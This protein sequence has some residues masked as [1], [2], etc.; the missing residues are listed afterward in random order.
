MNQWVQQRGGYPNPINPFLTLQPLCSSAALS[1]AAGD[2]EGA[3]HPSWAPHSS[4]V[5]H[6]TLEPHT[7]RHPIPPECLIPLTALFPLAAPMPLAP[8]H[9]IPP[10]FPY[11]ECIPSCC[12]CLFPGAGLFCSHP[13]LCLWLV[14]N[15]LLLQAVQFHSQ[16]VM[17]F[18]AACLCLQRVFISERGLAVLTAALSN[19]LIGVSELPTAHT[20]SFASVFAVG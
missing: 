17:C 4:W 19:I 11:L 1:Q 6:R 12:L 8:G 14:T 16:Y 3:P 10:V 18:R 13:W 7:P 20:N 9:P 2:G 5:L 15:M